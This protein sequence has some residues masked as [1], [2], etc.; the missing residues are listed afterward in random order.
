MGDGPG[1]ELH[2]AFMREALKEAEKAYALGE[3]PVGAV[4]VADGAIIAEGHNLRESVNDA[5]AHAEI[6]AMREAAQK[7]GDWRLEDA[8]VYTTVEPCPMCAGALVQF[9]VKTVVYGAVDPKAGAAGSIVNLLQEPRFNHQ[10]EVIPGV[11]ETQC[12]EIMQRFFQ[13]LRKKE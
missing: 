5:A 9:R 8:T 4:V 6:L 2:E 3:V 1:L 13:N 11:L 10:V 7:R 12:R